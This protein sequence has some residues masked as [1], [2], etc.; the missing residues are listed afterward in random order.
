MK[1]ISKLLA[2][3]AATIVALSATFA[4]RVEAKR[5]SSCTIKISGKTWLN[6]PC[7]YE[8]ESDGSFTVTDPKMLIACD[9]DDNGKADASDDCSGAETVMLK[10]GAFAYVT[11]MSKGVAEASWNEGNSIRA[12]APLGELKRNGA[13]WS[14]KKVTICA[15]K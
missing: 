2:I 7:D 12:Q 15:K 3:G 11:I 4:Q 14:N 9:V 6:G 8:Q 5:I 1:R 13:C 10:K